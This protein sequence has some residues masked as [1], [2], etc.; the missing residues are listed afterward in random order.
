MPSLTI[1]GLAWI[2]AL[3]IDLMFG[4]YSNR[5]H[6]VVWMGR[7]IS[8][9]ET[10]F[11]GHGPRLEFI[12]GL[13]L[14]LFIPAAFAGLC[15]FSIEALTAIP[16]LQLGVT[17]FWLKASFAW[18]ALGGAA[19]DVHRRLAEGDV[20][21]ARWELRSLCSRNASQMNEEELTEAAISS[22]A[23]NLSD[24]V[25]APWFFAILFGVPGAIFY[26]AV[27]TMDAMIGY[28]NHYRNLGCVAARTDDVLNFI[29]ARLTVFFLLLARSIRGLVA[30]LPK[31]DARAAWVVARRDHALTPSPNG[32]W[33]MAAMA[34]MLGI[35]LRKS[36][37]YTLGYPLRPSTLPLIHEAWR[38]AEL[39][40]SI[41]WPFFFVA[42][43]G[44]AGFWV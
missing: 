7:T 39:A 26:R 28:K 27:N 10:L 29:P 33:P 38:Y 24:S 31:P 22:L 19:E 44:G 8:W 13:L 5:W 21:G 40:A 35:Q 11:L 6:P 36:G 30:R 2:L 1:L 12:G 42:S 25:I 23:E 41:A 20:E 17:T 9:G 34:G 15:W 3:L 37:V 18:K 43:L 14:T 32:G 16:W 4:E